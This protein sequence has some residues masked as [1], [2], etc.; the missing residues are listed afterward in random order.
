MNLLQKPE[1]A[2]DWEEALKKFPGVVH[3]DLFQDDNAPFVVACIV[4]GGDEQTVRDFIEYNKPVQMM[5]AVSVRPAK[6]HH[7]VLAFIRHW[8]M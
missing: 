5:W 3:V 7:R 6:W 4:H 1:S 2:Q 8:T